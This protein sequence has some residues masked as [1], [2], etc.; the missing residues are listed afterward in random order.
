[1]SCAVVSTV[2]SPA[3]TD[4]DNEGS[5]SLKSW[6][7]CIVTVSVF[8]VSSIFSRGLCGGYVGT[9]KGSMCLCIWRSTEVDT[10][11]LLQS[12]PTWVFQTRFGSEPGLPDLSGLV[13]KCP[14]RVCLCLPPRCWHSSQAQCPALC[15]SARIL[16]SGLHACMT[17]TDQVTFHPSPVLPMF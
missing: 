10:R 3:P 16:N 14:L 1:M 15:V 4:G 11:C 12:L 6:L 7:E 9:D 2:C 5:G 17:S 13:D 8:H